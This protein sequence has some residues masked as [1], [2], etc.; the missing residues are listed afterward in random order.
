MFTELGRASLFQRRAWWNASLGG[1]LACVGVLAPA[2][3]AVAA[4]VAPAPAP[5]P[6]PRSLPRGHRCPPRRRRPRSNLPLMAFKMP[7]PRRW[8]GG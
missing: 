5:A 8:R 4:E 2:R 7:A 6:A 1:A 3:G